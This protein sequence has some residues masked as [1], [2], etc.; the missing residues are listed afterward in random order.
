MAIKSTLN[1]TNPVFRLITRR[2]A[3]DS[4]LQHVLGKITLTSCKMALTFDIQHYQMTGM[5]TL[6]VH[7]NIQEEVLPFSGIW[8]IYLA[9]GGLQETFILNISYDLSQKSASI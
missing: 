2:S 1:Y 9:Q 7:F 5:G 3:Y 4:T 6:Y 8:F